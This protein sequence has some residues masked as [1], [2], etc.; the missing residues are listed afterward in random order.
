MVLLFFSVK[1][2]HSRTKCLQIF[3]QKKFSNFCKSLGNSFKVQLNSDDFDTNFSSPL[4]TEKC[5]LGFLTVCAI[6]LTD[7]LFHMKAVIHEGAD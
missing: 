2:V 6:L 3:S 1:I 5:I 7:K 4:G